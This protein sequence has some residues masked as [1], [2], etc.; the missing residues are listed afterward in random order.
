MF[1][2]QH[3]NLNIKSVS[4]TEV[5][6]SH[7]Q[8]LCS[9]LQAWAVKAARGTHAPYRIIPSTRKHGIMRT[10]QLAVSSVPPFS[11]SECRAVGCITPQ[12]KRATHAGHA[13]ELLRHLLTHLCYE[14]ASSRNLSELP[15]PNAIDAVPCNSTS[16]MHVTQE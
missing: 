7:A 12:S 11:T 15:F 9:Q 4:I 5:P 13:H 3:N 2:F 16:A 10:R 6:L 14:P 1:H 8:R